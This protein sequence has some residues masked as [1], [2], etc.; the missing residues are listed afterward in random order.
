MKK[1]LMLVLVFVLLSSF[2]FAKINI[3]DVNG[4]VVSVDEVRDEVQRDS[5]GINT[6]FYAGDGL[7]SSEGEDGVMKYYHSDRLGHVRV[8]SYSDNRNVEKINYLPFGQI[9]RDSADSKFK[10]GG[11]ERDESGLDY[12]SARYY[13]SDLGIFTSLDP[14][15]SEPSYSYV[16]SDPLNGV[17]PSGML[18]IWGWIEEN[19]E[20]DLNVVG[21][22]GESI[23]TY[24][25][26]HTTW[27]AYEYLKDNSIESS[28]IR[29]N[30]EGNIVS[31]KKTVGGGLIVV[32][33]TASASQYFKKN[34]IVSVSGVI[35]DSG[36]DWSLGPSLTYQNGEFSVTV[37]VARSGSSSTQDSGD[38]GARVPE[39]GRSGSGLSQDVIFKYSKDL[40]PYSI[41]SIVNAQQSYGR[42]SADDNSFETSNSAKSVGLK[43]KFSDYENSLA[44][45]LE[46]NV[47]DGANSFGETG[48]WMIGVGAEKVYKGVTW[49]VGADYSKQSNTPNIGSGYGVKGVGYS[50]GAAFK[51]NIYGYTDSTIDLSGHSGPQ[52]NGVAASWAFPF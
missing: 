3:P 34:E 45:I 41:E 24:D 18:D 48:S 52:G 29:V 51:P 19:G 10:F 40:G 1:S 35:T 49:T 11:K 36:F 30:A 46:G 22:S 42:K 33:L 17:D 43:I 37:H 21:E 9:Y 50:V 6:Y 26:Y 12:F 31:Y 28:G 15:A 5:S 47:K 8:V 38:S 25:E 16:A 4:V 44:Y 23:I 14:V 39:T 2:V 7:I 13:D 20:L 27:G 32:E